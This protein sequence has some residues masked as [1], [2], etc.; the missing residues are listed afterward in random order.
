MI[1]YYKTIKQSP[2]YEVSNLGNVRNK[3]TKLIMKTWATGSRKDGTIKN[4]QSVHLA[5]K[6][7]RVHRLV[8]TAFIPN[9]N[10]K[11]HVD[12]R[13]GNQADNRASNLG[14]VTPS[15]NMLNHNALKSLGLTG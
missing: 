14:W 7:F 6:P 10:H 8:A 2:N 5:G 11:P 12:H 9:P 3:K 13:N 1:E 15:E 4:Y